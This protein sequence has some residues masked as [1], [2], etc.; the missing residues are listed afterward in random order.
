MVALILSLTEHTKWDL[1]LYIPFIIGQALFVLKRASMAFRSPTNPT[2]SRWAYVT[3]NF[4]IL[5][6]RAALELAFVYYPFRHFGIAWIVGFLGWHPAVPIQGGA[7]TSFALG[8]L[9]DSILD[10]IGTQSWVP[11]WLKENIPQE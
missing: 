3:A 10:W 4:D 11:S 5:L 2:K 9:S 8:Y 7:V 6:I 1:I